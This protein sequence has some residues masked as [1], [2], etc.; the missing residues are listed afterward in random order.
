MSLQIWLPLT[1]D[2]RN[3]GLIEWDPIV[4]NG[5]TAVFEEGKLGKALSTGGITMPAS[6][7]KQVLNNEA[8]SFAC[9]IYV[10]GTTGSTT[11]RAM[12]FGNDGM[13]SLGGRQFSLFQYS[14][15][16]D[17]HYS[18]QNYKNGNYSGAWGGVLS[19][20]FP[21]NTWTH[22]AV[23]YKKGG[24]T[25]FYIN[26]IEQYSGTYTSDADSFEFDTKL[27]W[28][29]AYHKLNDIRLY[30]HALSPMEVKQISQGLVLHYLLDNNGFGGENIVPQTGEL[31]LWTKENNVT[32][33]QD[34]EWFTITDVGER[35]AR[36]GIYK[37]GI[38]IE[39]NTDYTFQI[40]CIGNTNVQLCTNSSLASKIQPINNFSGKKTTTF[41]TADLFGTDAT[42][43]MRVYI[44]PTYSNNHVS[45][46]KHL[47][48]EKGLKPTPWCPNS[49]DELATAMGMNDGIEYDCSGFG[50]NLDKNGTY[51]YASDTPKYAVST[52]FNGTE[53]M[54][55]ATPGAEILTLACWAK[56]SKNKSTSQFM[57]ADSTSK[58]CISFYNGTIISY[59][60]GSGNGTGSKC[61]LGSSYKENDWNHFVVVKTGD[62][63]RTTYCN[64]VE[65][66]ATTNDYW[67]ATAGF[68]V[69]ARNNSASLP[70]YGQICDVRAYATALS[71]DDVKSL[72][73]NSA[74]VD[75][76]GN[77]YGA[78]HEEV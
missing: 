59:F 51:S 72:Y 52:K 40:E 37:D 41:N 19:G 7:T 78:V 46:I 64:G 34:G 33:I 35:A 23:S 25:K 75:S 2:L 56:T 70:F 3:Q 77:I 36:W 71:A 20:V 49:S 31:T 57:V 9:W 16:N 14:T 39:P 73:Q 8:F 38:A 4:D 48:I 10:K 43:Y 30:N 6:I 76:S 18:W 68:F 17:L 15:C 61:T 53:W 28:N 21:S 65:L 22:L 74:Y 69:G 54:N 58:L 62:G 24:K 60:G 5:T 26:G 47:K 45:K 67:G 32:C 27:I 12:I 66:V 11:E 29:S 50:N 63:T 13:S 1:K 42:C 55:G 44:W